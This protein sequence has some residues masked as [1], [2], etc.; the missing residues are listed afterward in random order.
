VP[1][2]LSLSQATG[3]WT[4]A[5]AVA[6]VL[7]SAVARTAT[8]L[9]GPDRLDGG[10]LHAEL[11]PGCL[12]TIFTCACLVAL[13]AVDQAVAASIDARFVR[14]AR[15]RATRV[16]LHAAS[17]G[18]IIAGSLLPALEITVYVSLGGSLQPLGSA[19]KVLSVFEAAFEAM[20]STLDPMTPVL[21]SGT[22]WN[23]CDVCSLARP[24][25]LILSLL[26]AFMLIAP[27]V[28]GLA[29]A[30]SGCGARAGS[31]PYGV[32]DI[33]VVVM[34]AS[35]YILPTA[36]NGAFG[37]STGGKLLH[38]YLGME[39]LSIDVMPR[40]GFWLLFAS[41]FCQQLAGVIA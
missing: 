20:G 24:Q 27:P 40:Q 31:T 9:P 41:Y 5:P 6:L 2:C 3:R 32:T 10:V 37:E 11:H 35:L 21:L 8:V 14:R 36:G 38:D 28:Q 26:L 34:L 17:L 4:V 18:C 16:V 13:L 7:S 22:W 30:L 12:I 23:L 39:G 29:H 1:C 25:A 15:N 33:V 19:S